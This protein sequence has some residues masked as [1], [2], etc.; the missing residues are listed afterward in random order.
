MLVDGV[1]QIVASQGDLRFLH[2]FDGQ[3]GRLDVARNLKG[4][5]GRA[6]RS[7]QVEAYGDHPAF[8]KNTIY[9]S[10]FG[11]GTP[12]LRVHDLGELTLYLG[13][14]NIF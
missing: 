3:N 10:H 7:G 6:E 9:E 12:E 1:C 14:V 4:E 13:L 5:D 11:D 2:A 8:D